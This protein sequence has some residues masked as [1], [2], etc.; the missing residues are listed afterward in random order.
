M[1][2]IDA[3]KIQ[4]ETANSTS[5]NLQ[6]FWKED[7]PPVKVNAYTRIFK[8]VHISNHQTCPKKEWHIN[9][10]KLHTYVKITWKVSDNKSCQ[11]PL[12]P[13]AT[14]NISHLWQH[15]HNSKSVTL[16]DRLLKIWGVIGATSVMTN[17]LLSSS[18]FCKL[19]Y[20]TIPFQSASANVSF[21][22]NNSKM[23]NFELWHLLQMSVCDSLYIFCTTKLSKVPLHNSASFWNLIKLLTLPCPFSLKLQSNLQKINKICKVRI[24]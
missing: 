1:M 12:C 19:R 7:P 8:Y 18:E 9:L 11:I 20:D 21:Y 3:P 10:L 4:W 23:P 14:S 24:M 17:Q 2:N 13:T 6:Q 22:T 5:I 16:Q 15:C